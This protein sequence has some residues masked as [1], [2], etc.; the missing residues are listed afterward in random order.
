MSSTVTSLNSGDSKSSACD[1]DDHLPHTLATTLVPAEASPHEDDE[2]Q[3]M[4]IKQLFTK[5]F[6]GF[7]R[8]RS[9][10]HIDMKLS[11]FHLSAASLYGA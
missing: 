7:Y 11:P 2:V 10:W 1:D 3:R 4:H 9:K 6:S 5:I 8:P